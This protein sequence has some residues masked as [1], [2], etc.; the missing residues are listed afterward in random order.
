VSERLARSGVV[1]LAGAGVGAVLAL[2]IPVLVG[3]SLGDVGV[4]RFYVIVAAF[5]I[6]SNVLELGAD[7]GLVRM[8]SRCVALDRAGELGQLVRA[9]LLPVLAIGVVASALAW[10][11]APVFLPGDGA[12]ILVPLFREV[13]PF[14]L[15]T[16]LV[17]VLLGASRGI[18]SVVPFTAIWSVGLPLARVVLVGVATLQGLA[19]VAVVRA[20]AWPTAAALVVSIVV[21]R[22]QLREISDASTT[23][24][25]EQ[26]MSAV[27]EFWTFSAPRGVAAALEILQNWV[28]VLLVAA[29]RSAPEAG[30]YA[31]VSRTTSSGLL[32]DGAARIATAPRISGLM[33]RHDLAGVST[34]QVNVSRAMVLLAWPFYLTLMLFGVVVLR[35]FGADASTGAVALAVLCVAMMIQITGGMIQTILLMGGRS[36]WQLGNRAAG[37]ALMI[38]GDLALVPTFGIVGAAVAWSAAI[39]FDTTLASWQVGRRLH[40]PLRLIQLMRPAT[41][42]FVVIGGGGLIVRGWLGA[43]VTALGVHVAVFGS[44]HLVLCYCWRDR[45]GLDVGRAFARGDRQAQVTIE[46]TP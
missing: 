5:T 13:L 1:S 10:L 24:S 4:G 30:V 16:S 32:V 27:R 43:T 6:L 21:V 33:A 39:V 35:V 11:L 25:V 38:V 23:R 9:A 14:V 7:T 34:V 17:A 46:R 19:F 22:R 45:L 40:V 8:T 31:I 15:M 20:W 36:R 44:L 29:L 3:R 28:D 37:L 42:T 26:P 2:L 41:M 12:S 18:G